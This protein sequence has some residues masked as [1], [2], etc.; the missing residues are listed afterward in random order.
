MR[1]GSCM[2]CPMP[3]LSESAASMMT[4]KRAILNAI[5]S[6]SCRSLGLRAARLSGHL[7]DDFEVPHREA[8]DLDLSQPGF[9]D[10]KPADG[11]RP[12]RQGAD[13]ERPNGECS[14]CDLPSSER[15]YLSASAPTRKAR[16]RMTT[17]L[18]LRPSL[19]HFG[20]RPKCAAQSLRLIQRLAEAEQ[21]E[22]HGG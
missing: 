12:D 1:A 17:P 18:L 13:R 7:F 21:R 14:K 22:R 19:L 4:T 10:F 11:E 15:P 3:T 6:P 8:V 2:R 9:A 16:G 5:A 20:P